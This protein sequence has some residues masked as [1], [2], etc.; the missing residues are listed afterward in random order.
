ME[1]AGVFFAVVQNLELAGRYVV[2]ALSRCV[3]VEHIIPFA[4]IEHTFV[5]MRAA[6]Q[7]VKLVFGH[8]RFDLRQFV[9][10]RKRAFIVFERG[11]YFF[12]RR[13]NG[14]VGCAVPFHM[15]FGCTCRQGGGQHQACACLKHGF[16]FH[17]NFLFVFRRP[18]SQ[19]GRL[20]ADYH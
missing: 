3:E 20:K 6:Q 16:Y 10:S 4:H 12:N 14:V 8:A 18:P 15:A 17:F 1:A 11:R 7:F 9:G 19:R 5:E 13:K 2:C